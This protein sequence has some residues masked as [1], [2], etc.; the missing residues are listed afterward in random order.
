V[1]I[2]RLAAY[3]GGAGSG[4]ASA[5][6]VLAARR[7]FA[8]ESAAD[9]PPPEL[10]ERALH[11]LLGD[12]VRALAPHVEAHPAG[13]LLS[14]LTGAGVIL[15]RGPH[16]AVG[17]GQRHG[18][19]LFALL[20]GPTGRGRKGV[21]TATA[22][23]VLEHI[24]PRFRSHVVG[25]LHSAEGLIH[26]VRDRAL[27]RNGD[28][29]DP[30]VSDKRL[31]CVVEEWGSTLKRMRGEGNTLGMILREAWDGRSLQTLT[32][33]NP[34]RA[35][36]PHIGVVGHVTPEELQ[37]L[38]DHTDV[39]NGLLNRFLFAY[40]ERVRKL[41]HGGPDVRDL[42][43]N[44]AGVLRATLT[45]GAGVG[46]LAWT[47]KARDCWAQ[48]Y[49]GPL[50]SPHAGRL[51]ALTDRGAPLTLRL[52]MIYAVVDGRAALEAADL[53]AASAVWRYSVASTVRAFGGALLS[54]RARHMRDLLNDAGAA[55]IARG[56]LAGVLGSKSITAAELDA[57]LS[58]LVGLDLAFATEE[59]TATRPRTVW[60]LCRHRAAG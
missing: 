42:L 22:R 30:G 60:R 49:E 19:N 38:M 12:V 20:V 23:A 26:A 27:G 51:G 57:A 35:T 39:V 46:S 52:A 36:D 56:E 53:E 16:V 25:G 10:D 50:D 21:A 54:R 48:L 5:L 6:A 37:A 45:A 40:V 11:G 28:E 34:Q 47:P 14:L 18:T 1:T 8:P 17:P 4:S 15:G 7:A 33:K 32:K 29:G 58:E 9:E 41:P 13:V 43:G 24:D 55:G 3:N 2:H 59:S 44:L 31:W